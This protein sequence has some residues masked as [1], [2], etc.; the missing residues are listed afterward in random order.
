[1]GMVDLTGC[2]R[3][4]HLLRGSFGFLLHLIPCGLIGI[5]DVADCRPFLVEKRCHLAILL[6]VGSGK[7]QS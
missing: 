7:R 1:V 2:E 4:C 5:L 6:Q 3:R